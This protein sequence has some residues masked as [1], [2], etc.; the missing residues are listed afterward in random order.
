MLLLLL[1]PL[2]LL[3]LSNSFLGFI[4]K[5]VPFWVRPFLFAKYSWINLALLKS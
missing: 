4:K 1:K 5:A 3:L 2:L